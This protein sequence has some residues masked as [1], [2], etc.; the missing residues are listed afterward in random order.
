MFSID[1]SFPLETLNRA[2]PIYRGTEW[3]DVR[4]AWQPMFFTGSLEN[5]VPVFERAASLLAEELSWAAAKG[6]AV[7]IH[8][9][10]QDMT[11]DV[12]GRAAFG[13]PPPPGMHITCLRQ[14]YCWFCAR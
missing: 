8:S 12:I 3:R 6:E 7:N 5:Y 11:M 1:S 14:R 2:G 10:I 13:Y 4:A 9:L